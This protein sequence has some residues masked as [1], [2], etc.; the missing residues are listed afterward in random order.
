MLKDSDANAAARCGRKGRSSD[1][2]PS[3][4]DRVYCFVGTAELRRLLSLLAGIELLGE[5]ARA[6]NAAPVRGARAAPSP[7]TGQT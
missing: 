2:A 5:L 3:A 6:V 1:G 4:D 7:V